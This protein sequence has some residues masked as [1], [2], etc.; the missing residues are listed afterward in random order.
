MCIRDSLKNTRTRE[1]VVGKFVPKGVLLSRQV[2]MDML[3]AEIKILD[4]LRHPLIIS[5]IE[6]YHDDKDVIIILEHMK[7]GTLFDKVSS[8]RRYTEVE[9]AAII[10]DIMDALDFMNSKG[11]IHRDIKLENIFLP[12]S[13]SDTSVKV[14]DF[15]L[16]TKLKD[17]NNFKQCGTPGYMAPEVFHRSYG[18]YSSKTDVFSAG[19][20]FYSLFFPVSSEE[21]GRTYRCQ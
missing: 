12:L 21:L 16:A 20:L 15:D 13:Y 9:A 14:G 3:M 5:F 19:V 8:K 10:R 6:L 18:G 1:V 17:A 2:R 4:E 7:G 11:I